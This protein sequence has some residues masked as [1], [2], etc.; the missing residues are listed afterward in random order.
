MTRSSTPSKR[1]QT[2]TT[3]SPDPVAHL[4][5]IEPTPARRHQQARAGV[6]GGNGGIDR[7]RQ[8]VAAQHH[9]GA[10]AGRIVVDIAMPADAVIA[11]L[12]GVERPQPL[13]QPLAR[14]RAPSGPGNISG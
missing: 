12:M 13:A 6:L 3:P 4:R 1:P 10:A 5:L 7:R 11:D 8:H 14:Q 2:M 9:A